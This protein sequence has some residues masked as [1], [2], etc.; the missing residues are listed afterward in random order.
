MTLNWSFNYDNADKGM[1]NVSFIDDL[2]LWRLDSDCCILY[3]AYFEGA[4]D[5]V[6]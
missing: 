2:L 1:L 6:R 4:S 3:L 5:P